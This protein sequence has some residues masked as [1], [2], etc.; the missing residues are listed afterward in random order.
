M[1][2]IIE[3]NGYIKPGFH[4]LSIDQIE[5]HLVRQF[6]TSK[7]R[8]TIFAGYLRL[9]ELLLKHNIEIEQWLDGS[10]CSNKV[11]PGDI[12]ILSIINKDT[13]D[14][15]PEEIKD[16]ITELFLGPGSK[17]SYCCDSYLLPKV[18]ENH[19]HYPQYLILKSQWMGLFGFD[20]QEN[21]K[22]II[23]IYTRDLISEKSVLGGEDNQ[24][25]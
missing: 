9:I 19:P 1:D 20:R 24:H 23:R 18:P 10:F 3:A 7:T 17:N 4:N 15:L 6:P 5:T 16:E 14:N 12:D 13:L 21:P 2:S 11:N 8:R 25:S 22:G